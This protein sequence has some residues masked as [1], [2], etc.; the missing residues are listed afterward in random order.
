MSLSSLSDQ[1]ENTYRCCCS[2]VRIKN[3]VYGVA[4]FYAT[5]IVSNLGIRL[6][7]SNEVQWNWQLLFLVSDTIAVLC[8][9]YGVVREQPAFLQPFTIISVIFSDEKRFNLD[10]PDGNRFYWHYL[11]KEK[12]YFP[13]RNFGGGT[14]MVWAAFH[15]EGKL[16]LAFTSARMDAD[17]YQQLL[18]TH[19]LP[20]LQQ[21][22]V[23]TFVALFGAMVYA[24][25][26]FIHSW[27]LVIVV[28]CAQYF[29]KEQSLTLNVGQIPSK[30]NTI[31]CFD[32]LHE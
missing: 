2:F 28:R 23:I 29:R 15:A 26:V 12:E 18:E 30:P 20:F 6:F 11:R 27:F 31:R 9:V 32:G 21:N 16:P 22:A 7:K 17:E 25:T 4:I 3:G 10:G 13:R 19:L 14:V 1:D 5:M 24:V 8:L